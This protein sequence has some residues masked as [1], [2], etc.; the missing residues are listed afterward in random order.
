MPTANVLTANDLKR[1]HELHEA[2]IPDLRIA[3]LMGIAPNTVRHHLGKNHKTTDN[4]KRAATRA[5][6][7]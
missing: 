6:E 2:G 5:G 1:L 3:L 4:D 7:R